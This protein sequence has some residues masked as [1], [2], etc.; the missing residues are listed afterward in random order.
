MNCIDAR[1]WAKAA[2]GLHALFSLL[3]TVSYWIKGEGVLAQSSVLG[4]DNFR[5]F[6]LGI[7]MFEWGRVYIMIV[8]NYSRFSFLRRLFAQWLSWCSVPGMWS[9]TLRRK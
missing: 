3:C 7:E 9:S 6:G 2:Y 8:V 5:F 4:M 1:T